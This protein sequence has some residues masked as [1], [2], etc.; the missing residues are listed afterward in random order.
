VG[1]LKW[2]DETGG[3]LLTLQDR[4]ALLV[5]QG[6]PTLIEELVGRVLSSLGRT[7][8]TNLAS[9][10]A[11]ER[12]WE[13]QIPTRPFAQAA[14]D[15]CKDVYPEWLQNHCYRTYA[16]G[17]LLGRG[18]R[19]DA[20]VLFATSMLHD[21]GLT[22]GFEQGSDKGRVSGYE[23]QDAPCFAVRGAGVAKGLASDRGQPPALGDAVAEA[24][25]LQLNMRVP[26]SRGVVAHLL[27]AGSAFDVVGL[28]SH[29]LP[30]EAILT[31]EERWP[32]DDSFCRD[33]VTVWH[34]EASAHRECRG[35][36]LSRWACFERL[37]C[38][39][40]PPKD[41]PEG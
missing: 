14:A 34:R 26:R 3:R 39:T 9:R 11:L 22:D 17:A 24:I 21:L 30:P 18:L 13:V 27:N 15:F 36:F 29:K 40:W 33:L 12:G 6:V 20:Q 16:I 31:I 4:L 5:G 8:R 38:R 28:G 2:A 10:Q 1:T 25:S 7:R 37:I 41:Q 32:R 35:A 23:Q 19:F